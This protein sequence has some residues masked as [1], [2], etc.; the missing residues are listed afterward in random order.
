MAPPRAG[1]WIATHA[2]PK[3]CAGYS[4]T[5]ER[6]AWQNTGTGASDG[7]SPIQGNYPSI[8]RSAERQAFILT[9]LHL[10]SSGGPFFGGVSTLGLGA[11]RLGLWRLLFITVI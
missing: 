6:C 2:L 1:L 11:H 9:K 5:E 10:F 7:L 3:V 8:H 4:A